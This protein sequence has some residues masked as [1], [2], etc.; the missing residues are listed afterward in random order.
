MGA[1]GS[2]FK[3][4]ALTGKAKSLTYGEL[5]F[6]FVVERLICLEWAATSPTFSFGTKPN[7]QL[8]RRFVWTV[9]QNTWT[10]NERWNSDRS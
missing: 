5:Q 4:R 8:C 1:I 2:R 7:T 10:P 3:T 6:L 9:L